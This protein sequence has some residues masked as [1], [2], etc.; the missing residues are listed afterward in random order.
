MQ[1]G[2]E[3]AS[4]VSSFGFIW[5]GDVWDLRICENNRATIDQ[6][7]VAVYL[8]VRVELCIY[9][10]EEKRDMAPIFLLVCLQIRVS[11]GLH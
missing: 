11:L 9:L 2:S 1:P 6:L 8:C 10:R 7:Q 5:Q 3:V 4:R